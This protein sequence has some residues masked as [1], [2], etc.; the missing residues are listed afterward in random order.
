MRTVSITLN[1]LLDYDRDDSDEATVELS[2]LAEQFHE[3]L[4][5]EFGFNIYQAILRE[6]WVTGS[7]ENAWLG[8]GLL[9]LQK[10]GEYEGCWR[11][12]L[13]RGTHEGYAR[14]S[15]VLWD[16]GRGHLPTVGGWWADASPPAPPL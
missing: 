9:S 6:R 13:L 4:A 15:D 10:G 1:G 14:I 3:M 11:S 16:W 5:R 8:G 12:M 7:P 2:M